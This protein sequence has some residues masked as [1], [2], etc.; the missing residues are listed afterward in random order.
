MT[1]TMST[2]IVTAVCFYAS[3]FYCNA[4]IF[5]FLCLTSNVRDR[6]KLV[7]VKISSKRILT[8][9]EVD[10]VTEI[11]EKLFRALELINR[12]CTTQLVP[13]IG[14]VFL[15]MTFCLDGLVGMLFSNIKLNPFNL[16]F[17]ISLLVEHSGE[18]SF[19][20]NVNPKTSQKVL[21]FIN[22]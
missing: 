12:N 17:V 19:K 6:L 13:A 2:D 21:K 11:Y 3:F 1:S 16:M 20:N 18:K 14:Y 5:Q 8:N 9:F 10:L 22:F 15:S 7:H 4:I